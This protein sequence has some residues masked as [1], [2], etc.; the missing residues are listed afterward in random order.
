MVHFKC[1]QKT[2]ECHILLGIPHSDTP[3]YS[4]RLLKEW[5]IPAFLASTQEHKE[6]KFICSSMTQLTVPNFL[7]LLTLTILTSPPQPVTAFQGF[8]RTNNLL[9]S[10]TFCHLEEQKQIMKRSQAVSISSLKTGGHYTAQASSRLEY[11]LCI[12]P[13]LAFH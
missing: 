5:E 2:W 8:G 10:T 13:A 6:S 11:E 3:D 4:F 9:K 12:F 1:F 7:L